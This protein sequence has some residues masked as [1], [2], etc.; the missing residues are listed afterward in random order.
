MKILIDDTK[1]GKISLFNGS[2]LKINLQVYFIG[3]S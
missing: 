2:Q 3:M 1:N